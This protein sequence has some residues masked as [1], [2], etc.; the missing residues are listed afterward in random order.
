M[1][2]VAS[3]ENRAAPAAVT[4]VEW[5]AIRLHPHRV[6][7]L[8]ASLGCFLLSALPLAGAADRGLAPS[9]WHVAAFSVSVPLVLWGLCLALLTVLFHPTHGLVGRQCND[10]RS[11]PVWFRPVLRGYAAFTVWAFAV[12]PILVLTTA[13]A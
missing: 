13:I 5:L 9:A 11:Q 12:A 7:L 1:P 8:T 4:R 10:W 2:W 3:I 6:S